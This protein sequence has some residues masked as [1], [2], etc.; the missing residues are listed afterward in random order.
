MGNLTKLRRLQILTNYYGDCLGGQAPQEQST[1]NA[2]TAGNQKAGE[3]ATPRQTALPPPPGTWL[4][5]PA[6][7]AETTVSDLRNHCYLNCAILGL[8]STYMLALIT[9]WGSQNRQCRN[10]VLELIKECNWHSLADQ[11]HMD[12]Q[13]LTN[14]E[15]DVSIVTLFQEVILGVRDRYFD[16]DREMDPPGMWVRSEYARVLWNRKREAEAE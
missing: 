3:E 7:L 10:Q 11:L 16:L 13:D 4:N 9:A 8:N 5:L 1:T 2:A 12:L 6:S 14:I 15:Y